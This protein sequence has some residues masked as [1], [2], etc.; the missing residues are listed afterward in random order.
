MSAWSEG[1]PMRMQAFRLIVLAAVA[2]SG[3]VAAGVPPAGASGPAVRP[4]GFAAGMARTQGA[5]RGPGRMAAGAASVM[6]APRVKLSPGSGPPTG[7]VRV[8]GTGFGAYRAVD[9]YFDI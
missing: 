3:L 1:V 9:I 8:S 4:S 2:A 5:V 6:V 7:T